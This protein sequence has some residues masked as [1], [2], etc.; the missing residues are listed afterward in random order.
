MVH[1]FSAMGLEITELDQCKMQE[2]LMVINGRH[3]LC[4]VN[5]LTSSVGCSHLKVEVFFDW[6]T[7][8]GLKFC[9]YLHHVFQTLNAIA[10]TAHA[11][12]ILDGWWVDI[13]AYN[14]F[15]GGPKFTI[16]FTWCCRDYTGIPVVDHLLFHF[17]VM[18]ICSR[19]IWSQILILDHN[20]CELSP[21]PGL[22]S[23]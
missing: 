9:Y 5:C 21:R 4:Y 19:D 6:E 1:N 17:F 11:V 18:S 23:V 7:I 12:L 15:V 16:F 10:Y 14:S 20:W 22:I 3:I 13:R 8:L 2:S